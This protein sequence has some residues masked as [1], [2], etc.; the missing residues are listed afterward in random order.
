MKTAVFHG[1]Y[2]FDHLEEHCSFGGASSRGSSFTIKPRQFCEFWSFVTQ[3]NS[4]RPTP[5]SDMIFVKLITQPDVQAKT[6]TLHL[7]FNSKH[8]SNLGIFWLE[9]A[10]THPSEVR[11]TLERY[12]FF[13]SFDSNDKICP[14]NGLNLASEPS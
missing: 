2:P 11:T 9:I 10:E 14:K 4:E 5:S 12:V 6:F 3:T 13:F 7:R 8:I 1:L